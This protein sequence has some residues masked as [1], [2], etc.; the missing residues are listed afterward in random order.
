MMTSIKI[1]NQFSSTSTT[2]SNVFIDRYMPQANGEYV[3]I[4]LYL[5]RMATCGQA[6][7]IV[8]MAD[9]FDHTES[10]IMRGLNYWQKQGL[11]KLNFNQLNQVEYI[12]LL[13]LDTET[14]HAVPTSAFNVVPIKTQPQEPK[15]VAAVV[16]LPPSKD[17]YT[18]VELEHYFAE[19]QLSHITYEAEILLGEPLSVTDLNTLYYFY[20]KLDF[21]E[22]LISFLIE[23][24]VSNN[25]KSMRYIEKTALNWHEAGITTVAAAKQFNEGF[26][27]ANSTVSK[28][29]GLSGR[30]LTE[31]ELDYINKWTRTYG[32]D[33]SL[34]TEACNR[35]I[36]S[37]SKPSFQYADSIL[38]SWFKNHVFTMAE[39]QALDAKRP[40]KVSHSNKDK[41]NAFHN[42]EER[43]YDY[44]DMTM[45]FVDKVNSS[46]E[47][48]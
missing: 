18:P 32:M 23:Y 48:R 13:P 36:L 45:R 5:L 42:F 16:A 41:N 31:I 15:P 34:I 4:Y 12:E 25:K 7:T 39:V 30:R 47:S 3:K 1:S 24:C 37:I 27:V 2:L 11:L 14:V 21:S 40:K 20:D 10:D 9:T 43:D 35:T 33:L 26:N 38:S 46:P 22:D 17:E 8:D 29:F 19:Q 44:D 6:P 28:A